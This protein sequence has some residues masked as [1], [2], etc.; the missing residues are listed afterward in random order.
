MNVSHKATTLYNAHKSLHD[1][2]TNHITRP[3]QENTSESQ[4][5]IE[6][7][8]EASAIISHVPSESQHELTLGINYIAVM[9]SL[10]ANRH[11]AV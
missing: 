9:S 8:R 10:L 2:S 7:Q 6:A 4:E 3:F 1:I 5:A 11:Q